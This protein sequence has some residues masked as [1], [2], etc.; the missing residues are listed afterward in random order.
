MTHPL[1]LIPLL[2]TLTAT[3][4]PAP[5]AA[6]AD[7]ARLAKARDAMRPLGRET[8]LGP[9]RLLT[10]AA[11]GELTGL[12]AVAQNLAE[13]YR[14]RYG[15]AAG[16]GPGQAVVIYASDT[17]YRTFARSD[18]SPMLAAR[19]HAGGGLAVFALGH[20]QLETR[21]VLVHELTHL[22]SRSALGEKLPAWLDEGLAEDLAWC[23]VDAAGRLQPDTLDVREE[24]PAPEEVGAPR[25]SGPRA[26]VDDWLKRARAGR[27]APLAAILAPESRLFAD[28]AA[29]RDAT[30]ASAMLI[31]WCLAEPARS[32]AFREFLKAVS[33]GGPADANALAAALGT[34]APGLQ[35]EFLQHLRDLRIP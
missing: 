11:I 15:L 24:R 9:W 22:L 19:G 28:L 21:L 10:D 16:P 23:R 12:D 17:P 2:A 34:D 20:N 18:G 5:P 31:R 4:A 1:A 32:A 8:S 30:T 33:Q 7:A 35:R 26:I 6:T 14:A 13:A 25:E 27:I 29:R 3:P